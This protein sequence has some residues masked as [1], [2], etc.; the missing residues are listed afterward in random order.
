MCLIF[1]NDDCMH[2]FKIILIGHP[3]DLLPLIFFWSAGFLNLLE[4]ALIYV[5]TLNGNEIVDLFFGA[6][7]V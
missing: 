6:N 3:E 7:R 5:K 4:S 2:N 1:M